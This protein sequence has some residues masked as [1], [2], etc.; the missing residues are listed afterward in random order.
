MEN[1]ELVIFDLDGVIIKGQ[2]QKYF[3]DFLFKEG[4][5]SLYFYLRIYLWFFLHKIGLV[6]N[7]KSVMKYAYRF[8][9][10]RK[11][12]EVEKIIDLFF[13]KKL[14]NFLQGGIIDIIK[15]HQEKK[16]ELIVVSNA[17]DIIVKKVIN[18]LNI[19][20]FIATKLEVIDDEYTG[21]IVG[22]IVY[23]CNKVKYIK[24]FVI[25]Q[26]IKPSKI[27]V[28]TDSSSDI[29]LLLFADNKIVVNPDF[30]LLMM[31]RKNK[32]KILNLN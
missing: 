29:G 1:K 20:Y 27:W 32:W 15:K 28:Y 4:K 18:Y 19:K 11:K 12:E 22:D 25:K 26:K 21:R 2:S 5:V 7:P 8:L 3:L 17:I 16:R 13:E 23:G 31:A 9:K 24:K 14:R 6:K 10:G 30:P